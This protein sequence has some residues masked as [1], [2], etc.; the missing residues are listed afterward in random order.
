MLRTK[1]SSGSNNMF[2]VG[3]YVLTVEQ[4]NPAIKLDL[5]PKTNDLDV[6]SV[7]IWIKPTALMY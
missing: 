5:I 4:R 3:K 2:Q 7:N 6:S 1:N